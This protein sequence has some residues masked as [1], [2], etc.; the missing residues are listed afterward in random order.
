MT[1]LTEAHDLTQD[2]LEILRK[3]LEFA[4]PW[5]IYLKTLLTLEQIKPVKTT[6]SKKPL[7]YQ[8]DMIS[9]TLSQIYE[10]GG[11]MLVA[12]TG[13]GKTAMGT[14]IAVQLKSEDFIDKVIIICPMAC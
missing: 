10:H 5:D 14:L 1:I 4:T 13:L 9:L 7:I 11:S 6:Y 2:L 12:S 8:Q 3:W